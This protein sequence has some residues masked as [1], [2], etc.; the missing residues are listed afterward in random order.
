MIAHFSY[1]KFLFSFKKNTI[2]QTIVCVCA[3]ASMCVY[4]FQFFNLVKIPL[5]KNKDKILFSWI[6]WIFFFLVD[7]K[8][9][10][11]LM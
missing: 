5:K 1:I 10:F 2:S 11:F 6:F 3:R 7:K 9:D 8:G 4:F